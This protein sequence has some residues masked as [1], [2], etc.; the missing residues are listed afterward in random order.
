MASPLPNEGPGN[1]SDN[2]RFGCNSRIYISASQVMDLNNF[3]RISYRLL[4]ASVILL[5]GCTG[6]QAPHMESPSSYLL[7]A[8]TAIPAT[9]TKRNL[10]LAVSMPRARPGFDTQRMA[11]VRQPHE[12]DYFATHQWVDTPSH[13]LAPLLTQA[14]EQSAGFGA[15]VQSPGAVAADVRLDTELVRLQQD[16][17]TQPSRV[18]LVLRAQLIDVRSKRVLA[19]KQFDET[20]IAPVDNPYGGVTAANRALQRILEQLTAFCIN[21]SARQ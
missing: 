19:T 11:Y 17:E 16:F 4:L 8:K 2:E 6:L 20:E 12:L 5:A 15:V 10:V 13:M 9:Q 3:N 14:L 1:D 21:E 18:N 7:D